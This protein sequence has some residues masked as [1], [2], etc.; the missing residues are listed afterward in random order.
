[1]FGPVSIIL[2][3]DV[4]GVPFLFDREDPFKEL[5]VQVIGDHDPAII[6]Q[7]LVPLGFGLMADKGDAIDLQFFRGG[8]ELH[9]HG[10]VE[11]RIDDGPFF[12]DKIMESLF[13]GL[14]ATGYANGSPTNDDQIE[15][16]HYKALSFK[17]AM[18]AKGSSLLKTKLPATRISAP[19]W[20]SFKALP[21]LTPPSISIRV[22]AFL[23]S[24]K[25]FS[26][27]TFK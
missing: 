12:D 9:I 17:S 15:F 1:I 8:E 3:L 25:L 2:G 5:D 10:I 23:W 4:E 21:A 6:F 27:R 7:G 14:Q 18:V 26:S 22:L 11:Q 19:A 13:F 20:V 24:I 16:L